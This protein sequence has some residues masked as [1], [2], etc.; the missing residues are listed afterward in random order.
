M[1]KVRW[2]KGRPCWKI[3]KLFYFC[4]LK[5]LV[6]PEAFGPY[7]VHVVITQKR[8]MKSSCQWTRRNF[9]SSILLHRT[10]FLMNYIR[11]S[12]S[13]RNVHGV[14]NRLRPRQSSVPIRAVTRDFFYSPNRPDRLSGQHSVTSFLPGC[15]ATGEWSSLLTSIYCRR[16][17]WVE[18]YL[19][20]PH[21]PSRRGKGI[22]L[23]FFRTKISSSFVL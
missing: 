2:N 20:S 4:H 11:I 18:L 5:K 12:D 17:E 3:A 23:L 6:R 13:R 21:T 19:Y 15:T 8:N 10:L 9:T 22:I 7:Y 16:L 1:C 14:Q